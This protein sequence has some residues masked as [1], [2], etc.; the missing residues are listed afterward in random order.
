MKTEMT[1][2]RLP[3][4]VKAAL[5]AMAKAED[6]PVAYIIKRAIFGELRKGGRL[7]KE[8]RK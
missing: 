2:L 7:N 4:D 6:R 1:C 3:S 5:E 8:R